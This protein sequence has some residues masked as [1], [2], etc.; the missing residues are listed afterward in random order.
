MYE[1][2]K[3][4]SKVYFTKP[5]AGKLGQRLKGERIRRGWTVTDFSAVVGISQSGLTGIENRNRQPRLETLVAMCQV[6][7]CSCDWLLGIEE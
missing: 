5:G 1:C 2:R 3:T 4:S 6:L 7:E